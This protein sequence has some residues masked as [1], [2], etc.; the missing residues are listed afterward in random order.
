MPNGPTL[1]RPSLPAVAA[2][3]CALLGLFVGFAGASLMLA[4]LWSE[5]PPSQ[6]MTAA[7][8]LITGVVNWKASRGIRHARG[9]S[10]LMSA[11]VT[12]ALVGYSAIVLRDFGETFWLHTAYL[13]LLG[14][15]QRQRMRRAPAAA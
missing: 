12:A 1:S 15:L 9:Q 3:A 7:I 5:Q 11:L 8:L 10:I 2:A 13:L 14:A 4:V 6:A